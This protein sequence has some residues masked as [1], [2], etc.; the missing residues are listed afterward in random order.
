LPDKSSTTQKSPSI[1]SSFPS[2]IFDPVELGV[3][4]RDFPGNSFIVYPASTEKM[5]ARANTT[6]KAPIF[7][8]FV[9]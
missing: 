5:G 3:A 6:K 7:M 8:K 2:K 4:S 9:M 1:L